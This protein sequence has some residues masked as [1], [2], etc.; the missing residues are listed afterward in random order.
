MNKSNLMSR[1]HKIAKTLIGN[2]SARLSLA[3]KMVW[4]EIKK[5]VN[6]MVEMVGTE[7]QVNYAKDLKDAVK[8]AKEKIFEKMQNKGFDLKNPKVVEFL[9]YIKYAN[10]S[11]QELKD[12]E[13]VIRTCK[14]I[15][16]KTHQAYSNSTV[17]FVDLGQN[18][19]EV[20]S[21]LVYNGIIEEN[22]MVENALLRM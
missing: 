21:S 18:Y 20:I 22:K 5:G 13:M 11:V 4:A 15:S 17:S 8:S 7:K 10:D 16:T 3:L 2:Y 12:A 14:W 9:E 1:A 6:T 19:K